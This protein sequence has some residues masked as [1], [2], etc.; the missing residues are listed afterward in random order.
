VNSAGNTDNC[1]PWAQES[2]QVFK[3]ELKLLLPSAVKEA[4]TDSKIGTENDKS[5]TKFLERMMAMVC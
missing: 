3:S 2:F 4:A 5:T 1:W